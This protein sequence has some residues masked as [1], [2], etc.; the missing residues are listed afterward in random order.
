MENFIIFTK[1]KHVICTQVFLLREWLV[2][3]T[4][5]NL[6]KNC[7]PNSQSKQS[8]ECW[9]YFWVFGVFT[10]AWQTSTLLWVSSLHWKCSIGYQMW[11]LWILWWFCWLTTAGYRPALIL[12]SNRKNIK[13]KKINLEWFF[14]WSNTLFV[15]VFAI[16]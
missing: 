1:F 16:Y 6:K 15:I 7:L 14:Y 3:C 12:K 8:E 5:P 4:K 13:G 9:E 11:V 2:N 10:G